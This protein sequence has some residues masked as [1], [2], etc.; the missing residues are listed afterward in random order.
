MGSEFLI[1]PSQFESL[2]MVTLEAWALG[3]PVVANGRTEVLQGQCR[4]SNA[5]LWYTDYEEFREVISL[6]SE[7][8]NLRKTLGE[9]GKKFFE[10]NYSWSVIEGKYLNIIDQLDNQR[11]K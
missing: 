7:D 2:S 4:R 9:N 8:E 6:M 10:D 1:I 5:G 11:Q 3:K